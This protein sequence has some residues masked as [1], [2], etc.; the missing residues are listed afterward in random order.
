MT[1]RERVVATIGCLIA[2]LMLSVAWVGPAL[3]AVDA[4]GDG[5]GFDGD[6]LGVPLAIAAAV[7]VG[8]IAVWRVRARRTRLE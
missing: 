6:E 3:A 4:D 8:G 7:V 1:L 5:D 2:A